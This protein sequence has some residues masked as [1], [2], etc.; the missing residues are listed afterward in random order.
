MSNAKINILKPKRIN[1]GHKPFK[2]IQ[3]KCVDLRDICKRSTSQPVTHWRWKKFTQGDL[4][5]HCSQKRYLGE[6]N[7]CIEW[8]FQYFLAIS[9]ATLNERNEEVTKC[10]SFVYFKQQKLICLTYS[11]HLTSYP[12]IG[13][14][15]Y[16]QI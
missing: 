4:T 14:S 6:G 10:F 15:Y 7:L 8:I 2:C 5:N 13:H 12:E 3:V 11:K 1:R 16:V 9:G